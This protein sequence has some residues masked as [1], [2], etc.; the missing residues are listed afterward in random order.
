M[1]DKNFI[2]ELKALEDQKE[3]KRQ[4]IEYAESFNIQVKKSRSFDN[5]VL[6]ISEKMSELSGEPM[7]EKNEGLLIGDLIQAVD[8]AEGKAVFNEASDEAKELINSVSDSVETKEIVFEVK[9]PEYTPNKIEVIEP[10][11]ELEEVVVT[12]EVEI[13]LE[14][15][16]EVEPT[17]QYELPSNFS[18]TIILIGKNPGYYTCPFWI[19]DWISKNPDWTSNPKSF[20]KASVH[21]TLLS[22]LY[23]IKRDGKVIIRETRNSSFITLS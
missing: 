14:P 19:Y 15:I 2:T 17:T 10:T 11:Q 6:D 23:Y 5:L 9:Q 20:P 18:P 22:L 1:I 16:P 8:E 12:A 3:A 21:N 4:L 7:P 13:V